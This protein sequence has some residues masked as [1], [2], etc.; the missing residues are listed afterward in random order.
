MRTLVSIRH[1]YGDSSRGYIAKGH[2]QYD[3]VKLNDVHNT[4]CDSITFSNEKYAISNKEYAVSEWS[5]WLVVHDELEDGKKGE[6]WL[7]KSECDQFFYVID[8]K[9]D[10]MESKE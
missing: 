7:R 3:T 9:C 6:L 2:P 8:E 4:A 1:R 10:T 5:E